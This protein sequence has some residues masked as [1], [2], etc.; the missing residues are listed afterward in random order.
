MRNLT[1]WTGNT[2]ALL[3][4]STG[5]EMMTGEPQDNSDMVSGALQATISQPRLPAIPGAQADGSSDSI[6]Y[7]MLLENRSMP[8]VRERTG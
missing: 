8:T 2:L 5:C 1:K 4:A 7:I 6:S 3:L